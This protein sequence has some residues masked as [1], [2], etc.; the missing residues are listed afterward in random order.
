MARF[1]YWLGEFWFGFLVWFFGLDER[2]LVVDSSS[3]AHMT[4]QASS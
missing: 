3:R 2:L 1:L 4:Q